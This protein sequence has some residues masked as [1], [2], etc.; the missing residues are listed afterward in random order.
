MVV[1]NLAV[2]PSLVGRKKPVHSGFALSSCSDTAREEIL[3]AGNGFFLSGAK[4]EPATNWVP[5]IIPT[6]PSHIRTLEGI[7]E[8][9]NSMLADETE[10]V[11]TVRPSH[12]KLYGYNNPATPHRTWMA[13]FTKAPRAG[14]RVFEESGL[15]RPFKKK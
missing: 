12:L 7:K 6:V 13:L 1:K 15:G 2:S 4:I 10:R 9:T 3:K 14:F 11:S 5:I 8:V